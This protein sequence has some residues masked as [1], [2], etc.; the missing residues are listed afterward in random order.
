ML[1]PVVL[2]LKASKSETKLVVGLCCL[3]KYELLIIMLLYLEDEF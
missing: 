1:Y 3:I 2:G